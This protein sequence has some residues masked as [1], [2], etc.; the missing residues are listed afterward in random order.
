MDDGVVDLEYRYPTG[1]SNK[2]RK[3]VVLLLVGV[4]STVWTATPPYDVLS[5]YFIMFRPRRFE[6]RMIYDK[7]VSPGDACG[8][9]EGAGR[10]PSSACYGTPVDG[11]QND[12][13]AFGL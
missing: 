11:T 9:S 12:E 6:E 3:E 10:Q 13:S 5:K 4:G 7:I 2:D 1:V 8:E